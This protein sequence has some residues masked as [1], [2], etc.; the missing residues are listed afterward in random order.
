MSGASLAPP[1]TADRATR[2]YSLTMPGAS[3]S[4]LPG[5]APA[6]AFHTFTLDM[7]ASRC[8]FCDRTTLPP[9]SAPV[10]VTLADPSKGPV[11]A[12]SPL[13]SRLQRLYPAHCQVFTSPRS[14]RTCVC[15]SA[16]EHGQAVTY[17]RSPV[18]LGRVCTPWLPSLF[19]LSCGTTD[20]VT[21][22]CHAFV[23]CTPASL[24]LVFPGLFP[25]PAPPY[26]PC[27]EGR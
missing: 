27:I 21:P 5:T 6:E 16:R 18:G 2:S 25:S 20:S 12:R 14:L 13:F 11:L 23:A 3:E 10:P 22:P 7:G 4:A 1:A 15:R 24:S 26:L 9:L 19:R 17:P 8:F